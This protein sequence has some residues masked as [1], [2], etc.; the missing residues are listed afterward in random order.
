MPFSQ[1][2]K[3]VEKDRSRRSSM[4]GNEIT[5]TL[6]TGTAGDGTTKFRTY[7]PPQ[8]E[9]LANKLAE[10]ATSRSTPSPKRPARGP[11]CSIRGRPS[12]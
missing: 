5:G 2:L 12:C 1:F 9:G 8:Y 4:T 6:K 7:A 10:K 3:E 11:R